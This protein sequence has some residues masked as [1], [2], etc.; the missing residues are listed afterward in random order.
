VLSRRPSKPAVDDDLQLTPEEE[1]AWRLGVERVRVERREALRERGLSWRE[2]FFFD[3]AKWWVGLAF[4]VVDSWV[5]ASWIANGSLSSLGE[6]GMGLSLVLAVYV[7]LLAYRYLWRRP[8]EHDLRPRGGFRPT[9]LTP[10]QF[11]RWTPEGVRQR[12]V[13]A[14]GASDDGTPSPHDFL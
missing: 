2:W 11:G 14:P 9:W 12:A 3:H 1:E 8:G 5:A 7:E 6:L 13:G 4:L 10:R